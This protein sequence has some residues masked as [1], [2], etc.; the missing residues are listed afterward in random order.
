V[1]IDAVVG[2]SLLSAEEAA[3]AGLARVRTAS[4]LDEI[5]AAAYALGASAGPRAAS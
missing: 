5:E 3:R 2:R 4:T 1:P